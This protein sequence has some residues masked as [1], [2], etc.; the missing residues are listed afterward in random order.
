MKI[1]IGI[2]PHVDKARGVVTGLS[3]M[4]KLTLDILGSSGFRVKSVNLNNRIHKSGSDIAK[5]SIYNFINYALIFTEIIWKMII[6]RKAIIYIN[7]APTRFGLKRDSLVVKLAILFGHKIVFHQFGALFERFYNDQTEK[8]R[9][10]IE[11]TYNKVDTLIIEGAFAKTHYWFIKDQ[12]KIYV[13]N[14]GL[15]ESNNLSV[16]SPKEYKPGTPFYMFFMN[17][18]IESKGYI[19]V[20]KAVDILV[21]SRHLDVFCTFAGKYMSVPDDKHFKSVD[22]AKYWF[23]SYVSEHNLTERV[24]YLKS[25]F[26]KEK[27]DVFL[28]SHVFLL[29]SYYIFEGQ[30][31]AII[32]ALAYGCV[33][34]VTNYRLIPEMVNSE[35]GIFVKPESPEEIADVVEWLYNNPSEY[36]KLSKGALV[37]FNKD[38]TREQY[39]KKVN[40][41]IESLL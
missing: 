36:S 38:F 13:L 19:D 39:A 2:G 37:R 17:N 41:I 7:P 31:T 32:E 5:P 35:N 28:Q 18:M 20:L 15:P 24:T 29:P 40:N 21:N 1:I 10:V 34:I 11:S 4:H 25:V 27:A 3:M 30:P 8:G 16:I 6:Y 33:P 9:K 14:N 22:D 12:Q 26:G 23:S